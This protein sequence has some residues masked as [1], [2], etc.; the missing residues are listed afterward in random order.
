MLHI[1]IKFLNLEVMRIPLYAHSISLLVV[2]KTIVNVLLFKSKV[3][4]DFKLV[5]EKSFPDYTFYSVSKSRYGFY[6]FC[7]KY[8]ESEDEVL[9]S[10]FSYPLYYEYLKIL[11]LKVKVLDVD[12]KTLAINPKLIEKELTQNSKAI[13][14]THLF[15]NNLLTDEI[16]KISRANN[17]LI[18]EDSAQYMSFKKS[19]NNG[20]IAFI[21]FSATKSPTSFD[22][23]I[24]LC[25]KPSLNNYIPNISSKNNEFYYICKT[26]IL[27]LITSKYGFSFL[28]KIIFP[29][30]YY[31][32]RDWVNYLVSEEG[33]TVS[34]PNEKSFKSLSVF[35]K[36]ILLIQ[37]KKMDQDI[38][39][40][41]TRM[42]ELRRILDYYLFISDDSTYQACVFKDNEKKILNKLIS[43]GIS[44]ID[45]NLF[46]L[47]KIIDYNLSVA[48]S[49]KNLTRVPCYTQMNDKLFLEILR[50]LS[51]DAVNE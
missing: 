33:K 31:L 28:K 17:L 49:I 35:Q 15:G 29:V 14:V 30:L 48:S 51:I 12:S 43:L 5:F 20:D 9:I 1:G 45:E 2:C 26:S 46:N 11:G 37:F 47:S 24:I 27:M 25:K 19:K 7:K 36:G 3:I 6:T 44:P 50:E 38:E 21:S 40:R 13:I 10:A 18:I 16:F 4:K 34:T 42:K 22:G 23:G 39:L 8:F 41:K 32:K